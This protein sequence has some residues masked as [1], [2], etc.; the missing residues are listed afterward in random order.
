MSYAKLFSSITESSLWGE[1]KETRLLFLSM[2]ARADETGFVEASDSG[3]ARI[4]N[5]THDETKTALKVLMSPDPNSGDL[6]DS[7]SNAGRRVLRAPHGFLIVNYAV[8]RARRDDQARR[9]Y[10]REY[11]RNYRSKN[12]VNPVSPSKPPL[13]QAEA[14]AEA[15]GEAEPRAQASVVPPLSGVSSEHTS[16]APS[17]NGPE[18]KSPSPSPSPGLF[19]V[20]LGPSEPNSPEPTEKAVL[21][22]YEAYPRKKNRPRAFRAIRAALRRL[23]DDETSRAWLLTRTRAYAESR[24]REIAAGTSEAKFTPYP[25]SWF[26]GEQYNDQIDEPKS[27]P[28]PPKRQYIDS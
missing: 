15:E 2:L 14:E 11:M 28:E 6:E 17:E 4:S 13:A 3:L 16:W 7:P 18:P 25:A 20:G 23:G 27:P 10:M 5:L 22:I 26:N 9:E 24:A 1:S 19:E 21:E 12:S 8:Y